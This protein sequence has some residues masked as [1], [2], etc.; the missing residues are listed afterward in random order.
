M[1]FGSRKHTVKGYLYP[2]CIRVTWLC[3][4]TDI[5]TLSFAIH[6]CATYA[7]FMYAVYHPDFVFHASLFG[8]Y[9]AEWMDSNL[10]KLGPRTLPSCTQHL[11]LQNEQLFIIVTRNYCE[12]VFQ[13]KQKTVAY[14]IHYYSTNRL[15]RE[16]HRTT[17]LLIR[18]YYPIVVSYHLRPIRYR[19]ER[20]GSCPRTFSENVDPHVLVTVL[21]HSVRAT[22]PIWPSSTVLEIIF[23]VIMV[24]NDANY[25]L[26]P[27]E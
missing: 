24:E 4:D 25:Y 26:K 21:L 3:Y 1:Y 11:T 23:A 13:T 19:W 10:F 17:K 22:H 5:V 7:T 20:I 2:A 14:V 15:T 9:K 6:K 18:K 27:G 16:R 8:W 12:T